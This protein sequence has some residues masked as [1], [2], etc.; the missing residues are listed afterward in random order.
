[1]YGSLARGKPSPD[2]IDLYVIVEPT[3]DVL[4]AVADIAEAVEKATGMKPDIHV[5][6]S[7]DDVDCFLALEAAAERVVFATLEG[8]AELV[9]IISFCNDFMLSRKKVRYVETLLQRVRRN[10]T[11]KLL[12]IIS[13]HAVL[14]DSATESRGRLE[15]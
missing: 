6:S 1:M 13:E 10:N 11:R 9:K 2:D 7:L 12:E 3:Q 4:E 15:R 5:V 8:R 14:L